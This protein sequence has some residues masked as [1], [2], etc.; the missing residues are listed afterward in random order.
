MRLLPENAAA[1]TPGRVMEEYLWKSCCTRTRARKLPQRLSWKINCWPPMRTC[2]NCRTIYG[3]RCSRESGCRQTSCRCNQRP[4]EMIEFPPGTRRFQL[5][6]FRAF[7][8]PVNSPGDRFKTKKFMAFIPGELSR[9]R[10]SLKKLICEWMCDM[11]DRFLPD[12]SRD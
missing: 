12:C 11:W 2:K 5:I 9:G 6:S 8:G 3:L 4:S 10:R 1:E 7:A